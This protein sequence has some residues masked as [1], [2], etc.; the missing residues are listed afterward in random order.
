MKNIFITFSAALLLALSSCHSEGEHEHEAETKFLVTSPVIKDTNIV[1][2]YVSQIH[3]IS[4]IEI[5]AQEKGFLQDIFIDEGQ[6]VK[7]GQLLFRI[8][9]K[10][11]EAEYESAAAEVEFAQIEYDN[12][13]RLADSNIIST[14]QLALA[15][16][17]YNKAKAEL[18][19]AEVHLSFTEIRA[20]FDGIIDKFHVRLGSL[21]DE[22]DLMTNLSDNSEMWVYFNVS[23]SEYL[24]YQKNIEKD[25]VL[26]VRL[27]LAN[28][29]LFDYK[30]KVETIEADFNNETGNIAFRATFPNPKRLLRHGETG[31]VLVDAPLKNALLIPQSATFEILEQKY[32]FVVDETGL[33]TA[34]KITISRE[35][36]HLYSIAEGLKESDVILLDGLRKVKSGDKIEFE[37]KDPNVVMSNLELYS[38]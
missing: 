31:S 29:D 30:G 11:Y 15:K 14:S 10:L 33:V 22:G 9:P 19:M 18:A 25:S 34:R 3:A 8:M 27:Q 16:A 36:P 24:D 4:H 23:E 26:I 20:P 17:K 1:Q 2:D 37:F 5:R 38:E 6:S 7:K 21:I 35:L 32:V 28:G 12:A 13:A